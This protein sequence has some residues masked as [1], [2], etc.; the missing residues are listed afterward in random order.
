MFK[1]LRNKEPEESLEQKADRSFIDV[2]NHLGKTYVTQNS[3]Y[4]IN[5]NGEFKGRPSIEGAQI[6]MAAGI[7]ESVMSAFLFCLDAN[8]DRAMG[9]FD[10]LIHQYGQE[11]RPGLRLIASLTPEARK[12]KH[13][14]GIITSPIIAMEYAP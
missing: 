5:D 9:M 1:K 2:K 12:E 8:Y 7:D 10:E 3:K 11:P 14:V 13:R 4:Q 6:S